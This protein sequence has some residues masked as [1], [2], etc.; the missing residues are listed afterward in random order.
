VTD[1]LTR[2]VWHYDEPFGDS[3]A[4]PSYAISELTRQHVTVVLNGDGADE[5]F[6][7]Y[8]WYKMDRLIQRGQVVPLEARRWFAELTRRFPADWKTKAPLRK[9][10]RLAEVLALPPSRRYA[11]WTQHFGPE[12]RQ[13][14]YTRAFA[15]TVKQSD[16]DTLF[17]SS[18]AQSDAEDWLDTVLQT[19]VNLYLADDLLVKMDRAT[20]AHSLEARSPFLDHVLMEFAASLPA[21]FKQAWGQK[22]RILKASLRGRVPDELLDRPKMGFSVPIAEWFR[23]DLREMAHDVLL[24]PRASERGYFQRDEITNLLHEHANRIDH[25]TRLWDLLMLELWHQTFID[26]P[27]PVVCAPSRPASGAE[28]I[29]LPHLTRG[30]PHNTTTRS[31][32]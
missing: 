8:D 21:R 27:A 24:S 15:E 32:G 23:S 20:M 3:S 17:A 30:F 28:E 26:G 14:M 6:A 12:A 1:I 7:G 9:I 5:S 22:K 18:F 25:G 2:L 31:T 10:A 13:Q 11:Q 4:V 16:P 19:D 29:T